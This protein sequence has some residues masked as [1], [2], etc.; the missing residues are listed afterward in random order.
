[1]SDPKEGEVYVASIA[2]PVKSSNPPPGAADGG[3]WGTVNYIGSTTKMYAC[4]GCLC[5]ALPGCLILLCP[6]VSASS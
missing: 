1:M 2:T 4:L 5:F 6:Q 3:I